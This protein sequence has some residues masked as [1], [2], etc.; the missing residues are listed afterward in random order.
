MILF[1]LGILDRFLTPFKRPNF[2][3]IQQNASRNALYSNTVEKRK[4]LDSNADSEPE[5]VS[6]HHCM[7]TSEDSRDQN[8]SEKDVNE[9]QEMLDCPVDSNDAEN[10]PRSGFELAEV[11]PERNLADS[12]TSFLIGPIFDD[13]NDRQEENRTLNFN[14]GWNKDSYPNT[15]SYGSDPGVPYTLSEL[16]TNPN[17]DEILTVFIDWDK[18]GQQYY[19]LPRLE[20]P[21]VHFSAETTYPRCRKPVETV[22]IYDCLDHEFSPHPLAL[23]NENRWKCGS[24]NEM[25]N[26]VKSMKPWKTPDILLLCLKRFDYCEARGRLVKLTQM[27]DY[28]IEGLDLSRY[29]AH[30]GG[31]KDDS[32][33]DLFA[34][35]YHHGYG[36]KLGHYTSTVKSPEGDWVEFNDAW[37]RDTHIRTVVDKDAYLLYYRKRGLE[38]PKESRILEQYIRNEREKAEALAVELCESLDSGLN[39]SDEDGAMNGI[40]VKSRGFGSN[41]R[42]DNS[43][44]S[45][46]NEMNNENEISVQPSSSSSRRQLTP[47]PSFPTVNKSTTAFNHF[48]SN[49]VVFGAKKNE[50][51]SEKRQ[52][53][54]S[55]VDWS[56]ENDKAALESWNSS[57]CVENW[58]PEDTPMEKDCSNLAFESSLYS[59]GSSPKYQH[60]E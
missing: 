21:L 47:G 3:R 35:C 30:I 55:N 57:S 45:S 29:C 22:S 43:S 41:N 5:E 13:E 20:H 19:M 12:E 60:L 32:I 37:S 48:S 40:Q 56:K 1:L 39:I 11:S 16:R 27:V 18:T 44:S 38:F 28:P 59:S 53:D 23:D 15:I 49:D 24:C 58:G 9:D 25:V 33:Y 46:S 26:G 34:V 54:D 6:S 17:N 36:P 31:N 14:S 52:K 50:K 2:A 8:G 7:A 51:K 42:G 10:E 4:S